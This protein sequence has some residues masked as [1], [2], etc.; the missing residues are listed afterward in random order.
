MVKVAGSIPARSTLSSHLRL[1]TVSMG[2]S[3]SEVGTRAE[4]EI[5]AALTRAGKQVFLP[6]CASNGRVDLIFAD[7]SGLH[8]VQCKTSR[9]LGDVIAFST[10]SNTGGV[11]KDYQGQV[12]YLGVYSRDLDQVFL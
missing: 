11:R 12:D 4:V 8:R 6:L 1:R 9:V 10:C 3:P 7:E 5:A 2:E